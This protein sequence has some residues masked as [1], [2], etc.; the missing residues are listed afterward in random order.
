MVARNAQCDEVTTWIIFLLF[1]LPSV[2]W[3]IFIERLRSH[4][5]NGA[6][7][8]KNAKWANEKKWTTSVNDCTK[9]RPTRY[10]TS[11][12]ATPFRRW[13]REHAVFT[14]MAD[15]KRF[16]RSIS[17]RR[18]E[19]S[20]LDLILMKN[21]WQKRISWID[22]AAVETKFNMVH[23]SNFKWPKSAGVEEGKERKS[24][25]LTQKIIKREKKYRES[26][27]RQLSVFVCPSSRLGSIFSNLVGGSACISLSLSH[28]AGVW[29]VLT[30]HIVALKREPRAAT[31]C[32]VWLWM[33]ARAALH[34]SDKV[35]CTLAQVLT[36]IFAT[37]A[38]QPYLKAICQVRQFWPHISLYL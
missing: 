28:S 15:A 11:E 3:H 5:L 14:R 23:A 29:H 4:Q 6:T 19:S 12:H 22:A 26:T 27:T 7:K 18:P 10:Y 24:P 30:S 2:V 13:H 16:S 25:K 35:Y 21:V 1:F 33:C 34:N 37:F 31:D 32:C 17:P 20:I 36:L 8:T 38:F 9:L